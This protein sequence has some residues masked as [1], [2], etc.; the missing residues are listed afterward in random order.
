M[1][2]MKNL[3]SLLIYCPCCFL[4]VFAVDAPLYWANS[5][6]QLRGAWYSVY[7]LF[8]WHSMNSRKETCICSSGLIIF[9]PF[10]II[11]LQLLL[12]QSK[13]MKDELT[14]LWWCHDARYAATWSDKYKD[15]DQR[16]KTAAANQ[17]PS[18][19][20]YWGDFLGW[21]PPNGWERNRSFW[22]IVTL[23]LVLITTALLLQSWVS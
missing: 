12:M 19:K 3:G 7:G 23:W 21:R 2:C 13:V 9:H 4:S 6:P 17:L 20:D 14:C 8:C 22:V 15:R 10:S 16:R 11:S 5:P 18:S 1:G